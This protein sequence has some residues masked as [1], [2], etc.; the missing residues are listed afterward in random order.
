MQQLGHQFKSQGMSQSVSHLGVS[1]GVSPECVSVLSA[2]STTGQFCRVL[3]NNQPVIVPREYLN[4][5]PSGQLS[6]SISG[7]QFPVLS[8]EEVSLEQGPQ[9]SDPLSSSD[10]SLVVPTPDT[11]SGLTLQNDRVYTVLAEGT[12]Y[13]V[14][15]S[16]IVRAGEESEGFLVEIDGELLEVS[17]IEGEETDE[18]VYSE[19]APGPTS[20]HL[21]SSLNY[22]V[23]FNGRFL[24]L[25]GGIFHPTDVSGKYL[26]A[27][28]GE[29]GLVENPLPSGQSV[30]L[31]P[32]AGLIQSL[33]SPLQT[34]LDN[35]SQHTPHQF[36]HQ[37]PFSLTTHQEFVKQQ[38]PIN[39]SSCSVST[40]PTSRQEIIE[41]YITKLDHIA[42]IT[43]KSQKATFASPSAFL[44]QVIPSVKREPKIAAQNRK[45]VHFSTISSSDSSSPDDGLERVSRLPGLDLLG[46]KASTVEQMHLEAFIALSVEQENHLNHPSSNA[47]LSSNVEPSSNVEYKVLPGIA[48]LNERIRTEIEIEAVQQ[49][50]MERETEDRS[51]YSSEIEVVDKVNQLCNL[52]GLEVF[53]ALAV[54]DALNVIVPSQ[55]CE[56]TDSDLFDSI[57]LKFRGGRCRNN[58][59]SSANTLQQIDDMMSMNSSLGENG[60]NPHV[61]GSPFRQIESAEEPAVDFF[62][63]LIAGSW[64][65]A[66]GTELTSRDGETYMTMIDKTRRKTEKVV[67]VPGVGSPTSLV[68]LC[69]N[70]TYSISHQG[71]VFSV[72][73]SDIKPCQQ[74]GFLVPIKGVLTQIKRD[75][76]IEMIEP[77]KQFASLKNMVAIKLGGVWKIIPADKL[78]PSAKKVGNYYVKRNGKVIFILPQEV[79]PMLKTLNLPLGSNSIPEKYV[80]KLENRLVKV[81]MSLMSVP[82]SQDDKIVISYK[83]EKHVVKLKDLEP[84]IGKTSNNR[85]ESEDAEEKLGETAIPDQQLSLTNTSTFSAPEYK[86]NLY[87]ITLGSRVVNI[88]GRLIKPHKSR[89]GFCKVKYRSKIF[90]VRADKVKLARQSVPG[91]NN[92]DVVVTSRSPQQRSVSEETAPIGTNVMVHSTNTQFLPFK[93]KT[94]VRFPNFCELLKMVPP[95]DPLSQSLQ[96]N[97]KMK[98]TRKVKLCLKL[99]HRSKSGSPKVSSPPEIATSPPK[100]GSNITRNKKKK[101]VP[102]KLDIIPENQLKVKKTDNTSLEKVFSP[103]KQTIS[104]IPE[105]NFI[106]HF[107]IT[108]IHSSPI[109]E[110]VPN[111]VNFE[112]TNI[113]SSPVMRTE[114]NLKL[115]R[116]SPIPGEKKTCVVRPHQNRECVNRVYI[117]C[118]TAVSGEDTVR[119][120]AG[121]V[122]HPLPTNLR[123]DFITTTLP[124]PPLLTLPA[125]VPISRPKSA[126]NQTSNTNHRGTGS[127]NLNSGDKFSMFNITGN[128]SLRKQPAQR[129]KMGIIDSNLC[130]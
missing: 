23:I 114:D 74:G 94:Q 118:D 88:P 77:P 63:V 59:G 58:T 76:I 22:D 129:D 112:I 111:L 49:Q 116:R 123:P 62:R 128:I 48:S 16:E 113:R 35:N 125:T 53:S 68:Y 64:F 31:L 38:S 71:R 50:R 72:L 27:V 29:T 120:C 126:P 105:E 46:H 28:E 124:K 121:P 39:V 122:Q 86:D 84:F 9:S 15:G 98:G 108:N 24:T 60:C 91:S 37:V 45:Q 25:P 7:L 8:Y 127:V 32:Q 3:I 42:S 92:K 85:V 52:P 109:P 81:P 93:P 13:R 57:S 30:A 95:E 89:V 103:N 97:V 96:E 33:N 73:G 1:T 78:A 83:N 100:N 67:R 117:G 119:P 4:L 70:K 41:E 19:V 20:S 51:R 99:N 11:T 65:T 87:C 107:E 55:D 82:K 90:R 69:N 47:E 2:H 6:C 54:K 80:I 61:G 102:I 44:S 110:E 10:L 12:K 104:L 106:K 101:Q 66:K 18:S 21:N 79:Y 115:M 17:D 5:S 26:V 56:V 34:F 130:P 36:D 75:H 14:Q 40:R 43:N